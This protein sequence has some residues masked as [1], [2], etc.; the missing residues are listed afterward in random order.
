LTNVVKDGTEIREDFRKEFVM[1]ILLLLILIIMIGYMPMFFVTL[2]GG[3][4]VVFLVCSYFEYRRMKKDGTWEEY[5]KTL[6]GS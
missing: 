5:K 1:W 2:I 6:F 4:I 3:T